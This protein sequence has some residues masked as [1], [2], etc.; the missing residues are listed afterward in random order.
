LKTDDL[1]DTELSYNILALLCQWILVWITL[2]IL[3][4]QLNFWSK[5]YE[6]SHLNAALVTLFYI[7]VPFSLIFTIFYNGAKNYRKS[8]KSSSKPAK[9]STTTT[10]QNNNTTTTSQSTNMTTT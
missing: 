1:T 9:Q 4:L 6:V 5:E 8:R 7:I 10:T 2:I 3:I